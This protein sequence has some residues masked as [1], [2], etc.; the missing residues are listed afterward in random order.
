MAN[1]VQTKKPRQDPRQRL[2]S[3]KSVSALIKTWTPKMREVADHI[4]QLPPQA[5]PDPMLEWGFVF[6]IDALRDNAPA[7]QAL[8]EAFEARDASIEGIMVRPKREELFQMADRL[9][10]FKVEWKTKLK[11]HVAPGPKTTAKVRF[12]R[13]R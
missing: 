11:N 6:A 3:L 7:I 9:L 12:Q 8:L 1:R 2:L 5:G 13:R 10:A 4:N